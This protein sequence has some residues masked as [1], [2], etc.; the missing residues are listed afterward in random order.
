MSNFVWDDEKIL[1]VVSQFDAGRT[2]AQIHEELVTT[3]GYNV[4]LVTI[5]QTLRTCGRNVDG[6]DDFARPNITSNSFGPPPR[7]QTP[8]YNINN[9]LNQQPGHQVTHQ[10]LV[11]DDNYPPT[12]AAQQ[13]QQGNPGIQLM[14]IPGIFVPQDAL[15]GRL[16]DSQADR[17]VID[18]YR[19]GQSTVLNIWTDLREMGYM[20]NAAQVAASLNAQGVSGVH[21]VDYLGR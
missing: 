1:Y 18:A 20:V 8:T 7:N 14:T 15:G 13:Q 2:A 16:W 19:S 10:H 12:W 6:Y 3:S 11:R 9:Q 5:E 21:V 4:K 17:F